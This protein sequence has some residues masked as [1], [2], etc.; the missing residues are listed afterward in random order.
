MHEPSYL[1][2]AK[3]K[4]TIMA[5]SGDFKRI[6]ELYNQESKK[7]GVSIVAFCQK[8]GIVYS[9]F[10]RWYKNR[11]KVKVHAVEIV[12]RDG[13]IPV[14]HRLQ[15]VERP[16][17]EIGGAM[18]AING[19]VKLW[20]IEGI[21]NMRFGKYRLF[22][23]VQALDMDPYNGDAYIFMSKDRR[24][25]KVIRYK[26]HKRVLYDI[27][28][29]KGYKFMKPVIK[30]HEVVYELDFKYLVALLE[31]PTVNELEV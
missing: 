22:S 10:E 2:T 12:E 17:R 31:C 13:T 18:L 1:C 11:H 25:L 5:S 4:N 7:S 6:L 29:E 24:I 27:T 8:N 9:Q 19:G 21:T 26:N 20:Y 30:N 28:Y 23:E 14:K 3:H 16:G 15:W